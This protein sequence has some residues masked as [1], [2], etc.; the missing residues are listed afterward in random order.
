MTIDA[1]A[2]GRAGLHWMSPARLDQLHPHL[3]PDIPL[4]EHW[5]PGYRQHVTY[6]PAAGRDQGMLLAHDPL[7]HES[8]VLCEGISLHTAQYATDI[9]RDNLGHHGVAVDTLALLA[10]GAAARENLSRSAG[11]TAPRPDSVGGATL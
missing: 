1:P 5:G 3:T 2:A 4:G 7:W 8:A 9:A 6:R 10:R 11:H